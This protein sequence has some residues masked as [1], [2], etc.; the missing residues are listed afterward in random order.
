MT[1]QLTN[2]TEALRLFFTDD[3][4]LVANE[5]NHFSS[6][7]PEVVP[8]EIQSETKDPVK[9]EVKIADVPETRAE[10]T[11][12]FQYLGKNVKNILILVH[13]TANQVSTEEG[14]ELLRK[15]VKAIELT[16]NDFALLN[17]AAHEGATFVHLND[18]FKPK[19][20]LS[21]GVSPEILGLPAQQQ[22]VLVRHEQ[23]TLVFSS[24][25]HLLSEDMGGKKALWGSLKQLTP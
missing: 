18:F 12:T 16:A 1:E 22:N 14:R 13:D 7:K 17:Y 20:V 2:N 19:L 4:Y 6:R 23:L 15:I 5:E 21:F 3:I 9:E 25:L 11:W 10:K 24:G 8:A